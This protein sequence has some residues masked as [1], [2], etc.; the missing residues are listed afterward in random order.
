MCV[1]HGGLASASWSGDCKAA[2]CEM[3]EVRQWRRGQ[4][5]H[6]GLVIPAAQ[7]YGGGGVLTSLKF[8]RLRL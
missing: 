2:V 5:G 4:S 7:L 1:A 8:E 6:L 3:H